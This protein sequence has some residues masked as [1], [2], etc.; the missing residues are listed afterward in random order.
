[1]APGKCCSMTTASHSNPAQALLA[2]PLTLFIHPEI[3]IKKNNVVDSNVPSIL[4]NSP[5]PQKDWKVNVPTKRT[6]L[7]RKE[8]KLQPPALMLLSD[9]GHVF[10]LDCIQYIRPSP[11]II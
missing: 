7:R 2:K 8:L 11:I 3:I 5:P 9:L 10:S 4:K 6:V 1:M